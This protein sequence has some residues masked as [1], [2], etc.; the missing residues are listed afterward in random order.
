MSCLIF[1]LSKPWVSLVLELGD[2]LVLDFFITRFVHYYVDSLVIPVKV[3]LLLL[4]VVLEV[5]VQFNNY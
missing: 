5:H 3:S 4:M 2:S 1:L